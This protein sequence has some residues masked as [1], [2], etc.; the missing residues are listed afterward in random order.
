MRSD[1]L[2]EPSLLVHYPGEFT[3]GMALRANH[4]FASAWTDVVQAGTGALAPYRDERALFGRFLVFRN[5][6]RKF[7]LDWRLR[8]D[9]YVMVVAAN[10]QTPVDGYSDVLDTP[11]PCTVCGSGPTAYVRIY[12]EG[13]DRCALDRAYCPAC[14]EGYVEQAAFSNLDRTHIPVGGRI[15]LG[16]SG[17]RDS[18][19]ALTLLAAYRRARHLDFAISGAYVEVGLGEYDRKRLAAAMRI[20]SQ[21]EGDD[22]FS[23]HNVAPPT[24]RQASIDLEKGNTTTFAHCAL[25]VRSQ[26]VGAVLD[27]DG[28]AP[29][30]ATGG[31]TIEDWAVA[32]LIGSESGLPFS[33]VNLQAP[34]SRQPVRLAPL[35]GLSED[36]LS[37]YAALRGINYCVEDCPIAGVSP[38][39]RCRKYVLNPLKALFPRFREAQANAPVV[40]GHSAFGT[41]DLG[42]AVEFHADCVPAPGG[43]FLSVAPRTLGNL[44]S[45]ESKPSAEGDSIEAFFHEAHARSARAWEDSMVAEVL[46]ADLDQLTDE[47]AI[48]REYE[49]WQ[50]YGYATVFDAARDRLFLVPLDETEAAL[51]REAGARPLCVR[52]LVEGMD[53][54]SKQRQ[55]RAFLRLHRAGILSS[56][57][58]DGLGPTPSPPRV[59]LITPAREIDATCL[60]ILSAPMANGPALPLVH[61]FNALPPQGG[62]PEA[63]AVV[64][65]SA[66]AADLEVAWSRARD[67]EFKGDL[68]FVH[69]AQPMTIGMGCYDCL[70]RASKPGLRPR[71]IRGVDLDLQTC[72]RVA[73]VFSDMYLIDNCAKSRGYHGRSV[74]YYH[75]SI[76]QTKVKEVVRCECRVRE[77]ESASQGT[78]CVKGETDRGRC[79]PSS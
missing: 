18:T 2:A 9:D 47:F 59:A 39:F 32:R 27:S 73:A 71:A 38:L 15:Y 45:S 67:Q 23:V 21:F 28:P 61:P 36:A 64:V 56:G 29:L 19:L 65:I 76:T 70:S 40:N 44:T 3:C 31:G 7:S 46:E 34:L 16:M 5:G 57:E 6:V 37:V 77:G 22:R 60:A 66:C 25:C 79:R 11:Q 30:L 24:L 58:C 26:S 50:G 54:P 51:V 4:S 69:A 1:R 17:E 62:W 49:V 48:P 8:Q 42:R 75:N 20:A 12:G 35:E 78:E 74:L 13:R 63:D 55:V 10:K 68:I 53:G 72:S 41:L 52:S 43:G 33:V 14:F